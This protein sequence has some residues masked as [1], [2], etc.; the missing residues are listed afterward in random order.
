MNIILFQIKKVS[1]VTVVISLLSNLYENNIILFF[2]IF[3][4]N[5]EKINI[6]P[7]NYKLNFIIFEIYFLIINLYRIFYY[8]FLLFFLYL[9][10]IFQKNYKEEDKINDI[11]KNKNFINNELIF[12]IPNF[13]YKKLFILFINY[14]IL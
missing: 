12:I 10:Y 13:L 3:I 2:Y 14:F 11:W 6:S 5:K 7:R 1:I 8:H 9:Y 4:W